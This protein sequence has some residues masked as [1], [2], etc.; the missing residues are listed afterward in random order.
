M[1]TK[2]YLNEAGN[3]I[4]DGETAVA[5]YYNGATVSGINVRYASDSDWAVKVFDKMQMLYEKLK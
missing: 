4:Y 1:Q 5:S 2:Y 3:E